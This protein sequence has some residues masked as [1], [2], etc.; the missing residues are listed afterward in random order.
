MLLFVVLVGILSGCGSDTNT[1]HI[2][3]LADL[4]TATIGIITG[5]SHDKAAK[6]L[7]PNATRVYFSN[8]SDMILAVEQEKI[9]GYLE[10][11]PF[12]TPLIWEG[13]KL[14][15]I[16]DPAGQVNNGFVFPQGG[17]HSFV[18]RSTIFFARLSLTEPLSV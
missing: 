2:S 7:F 13:I 18:N 15:H 8:M 1:N 3:S 17:V 11:A 4:E 12:L 14:K 9:D 6:E 5:S 16:D 10:D